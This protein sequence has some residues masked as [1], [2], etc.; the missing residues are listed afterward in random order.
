MR[1]RNVPSGL[2]HV[3]RPDDAARAAASEFWGWLLFCAIVIAVTLA[4]AATVP[5]AW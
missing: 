5:G 1:N 3:T 2:P 4:I